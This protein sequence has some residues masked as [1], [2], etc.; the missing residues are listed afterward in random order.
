MRKK[1][2]TKY[3]ENKEKRNKRE[4]QLKQVVPRTLSGPSLD[5]PGQSR[6]TRINLAW[7]C[8]GKRTYVWIG[9]GC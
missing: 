6:M 7:P 8:S 3:K 1:K 4:R 9:P 2:E 5:G